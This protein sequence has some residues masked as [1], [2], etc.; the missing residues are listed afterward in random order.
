M[1]ITD[2]NKNPIKKIYVYNDIQD[3]YGLKLV[4]ELQKGYLFFDS[5]KFIYKHDTSNLPQVLWE[6][7]RV[8]HTENLTFKSIKEDE[9]ANYFM[10]LS[11]DMLIY[12]H[13]TMNGNEFWHQSVR[14]LYNDNVSADDY[15]KAIEHMNE[16]WVEDGIITSE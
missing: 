4:F 7:H 5:L 1:D 13:Q 8:D 11:N 10:L 9:I 14:F 12:V 15:N 16:D 3:H 6:E 2:I